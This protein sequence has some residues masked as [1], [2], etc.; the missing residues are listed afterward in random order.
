MYI[1]EAMTLTWRQNTL[2]R[3]CAKGHAA[4]TYVAKRDQPEPPCPACG[5][6]LVR[7][8]PKDE[9]EP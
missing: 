8:E 4:V 7:V 9:R 5:R 3:V 6:T 2:I 1:E